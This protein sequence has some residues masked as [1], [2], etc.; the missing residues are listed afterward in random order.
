M[1]SDGSAEAA[2]CQLCISGEQHPLFLYLALKAGKFKVGVATNPVER[3]SSLNRKHVAGKSKKDGGAQW[4]L[5]AAV[6]PTQDKNLVQQMFAARKQLK[7][8]SGSVAAFF[9]VR[10]R[11]FAKLGVFGDAEKLQS[12]K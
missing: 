1:S 3:V 9:A 6:G 10:E 12:S 11:S 5:L 4:Q 7:S 2:T 8:A